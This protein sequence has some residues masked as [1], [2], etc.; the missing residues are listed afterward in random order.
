MNREPS[1]NAVTETGDAQDGREYSKD[2]SR[3]D[4]RVEGWEGRW[5]WR[6]EFE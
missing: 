6:L 2:G 4:G 5:Q 3:S 1:Q